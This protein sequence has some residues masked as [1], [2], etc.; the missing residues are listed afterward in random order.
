MAAIQSLSV[1]KSHSAFRRR[2]D[3]PQKQIDQDSGEGGTYAGN[4]HKGDPNPPRFPAVS[5]CNAG[6]DAGY[7]AVTGAAEGS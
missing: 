2:H 5:F 6:A 1:I 3:E 4:K 7:D